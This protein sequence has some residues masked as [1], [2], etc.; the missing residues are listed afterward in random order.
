MSSQPIL[1]NCKSELQGPTALKPTECSCSGTD[2]IKVIAI[3]SNYNEQAM[4]RTKKYLFFIRV[5]FK[6]ISVKGSYFDQL[7]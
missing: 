6:E 5:K 1:I 3:K 4:L 2:E 7:W